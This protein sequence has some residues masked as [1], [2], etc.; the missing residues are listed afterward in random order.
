[1]CG[2]RI[3][4][5]LFGTSRTSSYAKEMTQCGAIKA[6][7]LW[8]KSP[9]MELRSTHR[10]QRRTAYT[11]PCCRHRYYDRQ[12]CCCCCCCDIPCFALFRSTLPM[13]SVSKYSKSK[14]LER[15]NWTH[16]NRYHLCEFEICSVCFMLLFDIF[17]V[18][19]FFMYYWWLLCDET[20]VARCFGDKFQYNFRV[21]VK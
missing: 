4:D 14:R 10:T 20:E 21:W 2:T 13:L 3:R 9:A 18:N 8:V 16:A 15:L 6:L 1:M 12:C 17:F 19:L 5:Q 11:T 7:S